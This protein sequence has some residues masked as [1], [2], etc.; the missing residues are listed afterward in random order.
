MTTKPLKKGATY[1][2]LREVPEH[3]VAEMFD[4][5]LWAFPRPALRHANT[6]G[7]LFAELHKAFHHGDPNGWVILFEPELHFGR[8]VLVPD[9]AGWRRARMPA[10]PDEPYLTLAPDWICE[11]L[12][13]STQ[14]VD[15]SKKLRIY[16]REGVAHA[17]LVDPIARSLEVLSLEARQWKERG[18]YADEARARAAP[19]DSIEL[20]LSAL[21]I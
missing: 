16:G 13:P 3:F 21:W 6:T 14:A 18:R 11:V 19:F 15:R 17:W 2:D 4:G 10:V 8:D 5:D 12:S 9:I 7:S 20:E 1:D